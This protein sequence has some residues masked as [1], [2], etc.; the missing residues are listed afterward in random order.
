MTFNYSINL[1]SIIQTHEAVSDF[2]IDNG[3][4][5]LLVYPQKST[6][7][8]N[9]INDVDTG[10]ST[11]IYKSGGPIVFTNYTLCPYCNGEGRQY[12]ASEETVKCRVYYNSKFFM[13]NKDYDS[14]GNINIDKDTVQIVTYMTNLSKFERAEFLIVDS[15]ISTS[16]KYRCQP[17][18]PPLPHGFNHN[19]Y[20]IQYWKRTG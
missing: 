7:C 20:F 13:S 5:C 15:D 18:S 12:E 17:L 6:P 11:G 2:L 16:K 8:P 3:K 10:K 4:N 9:C 19:R 1:V 14:R